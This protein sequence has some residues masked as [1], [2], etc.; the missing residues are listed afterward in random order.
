VNVVHSSLAWQMAQQGVV[1]PGDAPQQIG[2]GQ[3]DRGND[4]PQHPEGN[5]RHRSSQ[6]QSKLATAKPGRSAQLVDVDHLGARVH[7]DRTQAS[8]WKRREDWP[9][10]SHRQRYDSCHDQR[11]EL[12]SGGQAVSNRGPAGATADRKPWLSPDATLA[13]PSATSSRLGLIL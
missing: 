12:G 7:H 13:T 6:G 11:V 2:T 8:P 10:E 1:G 3:R 9:S 5:H 4:A